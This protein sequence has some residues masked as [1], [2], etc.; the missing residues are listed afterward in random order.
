MGYAKM[1]SFLL[2]SAKDNFKKLPDTDLY[3][4]TRH[5]FTTNAIATGIEPS[6]VAYIMV[7][8]LQLKQRMTTTMCVKNQ[9]LQRFRR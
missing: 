6:A 1:S 7:P 3:G 8:I 4:A 5:S 2:S 9:S